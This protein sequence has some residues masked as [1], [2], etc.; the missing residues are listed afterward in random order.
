M[1][2]IA[3]T[4]QLSIVTS[5]ILITLVFTGYTYYA[6]AQAVEQVYAEVYNIN[7][8]SP[9]LNFA[10]IV[11]TLNFTNPSN[12]DIHDLSSTFHLYIDEND[13]GEGSFSNLTIPAQ[14]NT[15]KQVSMRIHYDEVAKSVIDII[16]NWAQGQNTNIKVK[17]TMQASVLFGLTT[18]SHQYTAVSS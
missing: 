8:V 3:K 9:K 5:I 12:R 15:Y 4:Y 16:S 10:T 13:V 7:Q 17:G 14:Q 1:S 11:F 6:D 18:A 2:M